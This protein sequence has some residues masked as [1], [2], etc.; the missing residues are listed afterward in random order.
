M[1]IRYKSRKKRMRVETIC[2]YKV[3]K[4][5]R[6]SKSLNTSNNELKGV[7]AKRHRLCG[8]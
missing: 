5:S 8:K 1:V 2:A 3:R 7:C 4:I 6:L